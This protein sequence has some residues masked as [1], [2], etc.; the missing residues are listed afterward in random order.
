MLRLYGAD[1]R[2]ARA[3]ATGNDILAAGQR[4]AIYM[5][6]GLASFGAFQWVEL[7]QSSEATNPQTMQGCQQPLLLPGTSTPYRAQGTWTPDGSGATLN[8]TIPGSAITGS[9]R[10][11]AL[12]A[13]R[14]GGD[15]LFRIV[16]PSVL[17]LGSSNTL[18]ASV[19]LT[20]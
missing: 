3:V 19:H 13:S 4:D 15:A 20:T 14:V 6:T 11:A 1:G 18:S 16:L 12:Y 17:V 10:E 7:G 8:V 5:L 2:L 9:I